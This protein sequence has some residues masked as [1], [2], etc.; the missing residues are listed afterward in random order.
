VG[1]AAQIAHLST[2]LISVVHFIIVS[3]SSRHIRKD[4]ISVRLPEPLRAA[5]EEQAKA[6]GSRITTHIR[7]ILIEHEVA[8]LAKPSD[9]EAA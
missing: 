8:R 6:E 1:E 5:L 3:M 7:K 9:S 4:Q 2:L